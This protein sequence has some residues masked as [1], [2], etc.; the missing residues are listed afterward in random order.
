[1]NAPSAGPHNA[2]AKPNQP[3]QNQ[4]PQSIPSASPSPT[5]RE[6]L[7][8]ILSDF[9]RSDLTL[10]QIAGNHDMTVLQLLEWS[11]QPKVQEVFRAVHALA[12]MR[13]RVI[14]AESRGRLSLALR[15]AKDNGERY[16][17]EAE[18]SRTIRVIRGGQSETVRIPYTPT[19]NRAGVGSSV[20]T[21]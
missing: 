3:P 17:E 6:R 19:V 9:L 21:N 14:A 18:E 11:R 4:P 20:S 16:V 15:S 10:L 7:N 5:E 13:S 1:M 12:R 2:P 8:D